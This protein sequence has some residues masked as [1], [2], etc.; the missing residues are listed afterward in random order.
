MHLWPMTELTPGPRPVGRAPHHAVLRHARNAE[1]PPRC[2]TA[3]AD[4]LRE[5]QA[6]RPTTTRHIS[7]LAWHLSN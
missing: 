7:E 2:A 1:P 6:Q 3:G 5:S 4:L